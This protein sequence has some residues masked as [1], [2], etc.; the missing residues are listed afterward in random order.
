MS[1]SHFQ[2]FDR[3]P[4]LTDALAEIKIGLKASPKRIAPKYFY[5]KRGSA[6]FDQITQLPEYYL[7][8]T[9]IAILEAHRAELANIVGKSC[10]LIEYGSGSSHKVRLLIGAFE[11]RFYVP[12]DISKEHLQRS[13]KAIYNDFESLH[14]YPTCADYSQ[15]VRLP[16]VIDG[17]PRC[18]F[19][20]GSSIGNFEREEALEFLSNVRQ[21]IGPGGFCIVG[22]D[23]RKS[24]DILEP[25]YNDSK[26]ITAS[27][28]RNLLRHLNRAIGTNFDEMK[29][30][31]QAI[32]NE[33]LGRI[34]MHL[35]SS[36]SQKV[37]LDGETVHLARNETIH[38]EN[39]YKYSLSEIK[40]L[41]DRAGMNF[42]KHWED[43]KG[44]FF[45]VLLQ[46]PRKNPVCDN[47]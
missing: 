26:G 30:Q 44:W 47:G 23:S 37:I 1:H 2:F 36:T 43:R 6:L 40:K 18:G 33:S 10:C 12:V 9:E 39:S 17:A 46:V 11:P 41:A 25:A 16:P 21:D 3:N 19:F 29:F 45:V 13:A 35:I 38:T 20:P 24:K 4:T 31:H 15:T 32:Y 34:E 5:D 42:V 14:V 8:R 27:F 7:T 28:N 22:F